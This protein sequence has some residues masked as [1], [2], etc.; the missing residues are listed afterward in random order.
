MRRL[1]VIATAAA[2]AVCAPF[3]AVVPAHGADTQQSTQP[4]AQPA[5]PAKD[6]TAPEKQKRK[7]AE[8]KKVKENAFKLKKAADEQHRAV[9]NLRTIVGAQVAHH[10]AKGVYAGD[11]DALT[12]PEPAFLT[13]EWNAIK[14]GYAY[15][16]RK[17]EGFP[18]NFHLHASPEI[19]GPGQGVYFFVDASGVIR[20]NRFAPAGPDSPV[21]E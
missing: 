13:G 20:W 4:T 11:F 19:G 17:P 7:K 8:K 2:V 21:I 3:L 15:A 14:D 18:Q 5:K 10:A 12:T 6:G 1:C 9:G 16:I